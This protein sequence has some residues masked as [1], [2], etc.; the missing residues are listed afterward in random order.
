MYSR[1]ASDS[2]SISSTRNFTTSPIEITPVRRPCSTTGKFRHVPVVDH[3]RP[4]G[5][6]S[7]RDA[8]GPELEAFVAELDTREHIGEVMR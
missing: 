1:S 4:V 6:V 2:R 5:V 8:L 7:A 3:D